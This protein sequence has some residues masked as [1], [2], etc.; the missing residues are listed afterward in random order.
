[1]W[2][3]VRIHVVCLLLISPAM[4][5]EQ[6]SGA[7]IPNEVLETLRYEFN[8]RAFALACATRL[9]KAVT[10]PREQA[11]WQAFLALEQYNQQR[12][13]SEIANFDIDL[14]QHLYNRVRSWFVSL[15]VRLAPERTLDKLLRNTRVYVPR[16]ERLLEIG[17]PQHTD[18]FRHVVAQEKAQLQTLEYV[19]ADDWDAATGRLQEFV[20][21]L[22]PL[23]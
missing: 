16:L 6:T 1:M 8:N 3:S 23:Q 15:A 12:Y 19:L 18:F 14:Q 5:E 10:N 20:A 17:P 7:D 2:E 22:Q 11:Y 13:A 4:A 21:E 9:A